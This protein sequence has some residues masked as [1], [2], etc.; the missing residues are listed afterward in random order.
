MRSVL[1]VLAAAFMVAAL[2]NGCSNG[3]GNPDA[4]TD[5]SGDAAPVTCTGDSDCPSISESC[6]FPING[7]CVLSGLT[8]VCLN[9]TQP[10][11]CTPNI[12]C[13]CDGTTINICAPAGYVDRASRSAGACP[14]S[15]A[16]MDTG[17]DAPDNDA[18]DAETDAAA[19]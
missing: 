17:S 3:S 18:A 10:M 19:D 2:V 16:G 7:G 15:D 14:M 4:S 5:A 1:A 9:Y 12:A 8:G 6:Y 11:S 13:G